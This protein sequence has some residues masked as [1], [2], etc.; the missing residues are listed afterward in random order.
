MTSW[1]RI[2]A[3]TAALAL[4]LFGLVVAP[5]LATGASACTIAAAPTVT[6]GVPSA[7]NSTGCNAGQGWL[8]V[9]LHAGDIV[10]FQV[11]SPGG[12]NFTFWSPNANDFNWTTN[13]VDATC[14]TGGFAFWQD[15]CQVTRTGMWHVLVTGSGTFTASVARAAPQTGRVAGSCTIAAAPAVAS[16]VVQWG[17]AGCRDAHSIVFWKLRL[18]PRDTLTFRLAA[19][20]GW[21]T[22]SEVRATVWK[23][24][25]TD[26]NLFAVGTAQLCDGSVFVGTPGTLGCGQVRTG[27]VHVVGLRGA[28][29]IQPVVTHAV[30]VTPKF[31]ASV[32][33]KRTVALL[34]VVSSPAGRVQGTCWLQILSGKT[35]KNVSKAKVTLGKCLPTIRFT[36][37]RTAK[38]R[39][40]QVGATGW[41][42]RITA[43][44]TIRAK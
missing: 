18:Y 9:P 6:M 15:V 7:Y 37:K 16:R 25:T 13:V 30:T 29:A 12:S 22:V 1:R 39:I 8:N 36:S 44:V 32:K 33:V 42:T 26:F 20:K 43:P 28:G 10:T 3:S 27:G 40:H 24:G 35:W 23:P 2:A 21:G 4:V 34:S 11:Q 19:A 14:E 17:D 38:L 31:P 5:A 41:A